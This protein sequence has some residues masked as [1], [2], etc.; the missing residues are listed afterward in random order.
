MLVE[1]PL[2][3][4]LALDLVFVV[5]N[6]LA[7]LLYFALAVVLFWSLADCSPSPP[8]LVHLTMPMAAMHRFR[9]KRPAFDE[10]VSS[11]RPFWASGAVSAV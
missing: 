8:R 10:S 9:S 4:L 3:G 6:L 2:R 11:G 7:Y 5:S 1:N